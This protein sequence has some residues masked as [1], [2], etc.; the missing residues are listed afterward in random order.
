MATIQQWDLP[1][2]S[3]IKPHPGSRLS[4]KEFIAWCD[5]DIKAEWVNG[6]V[7]IMSP[8]TLLHVRI[9]R[10]LVSLLQEFGAIRKLG[11]ALGPEFTVRLD[12]QRRRIPDVLFV[13]SDRLNRLQAGYFEGAPNFIVEVVSEDSVERD[14][15]DKYFEYEAAGVD[16]YWI[17]D[18]QYQRIAPYSLGPD[19]VY[20]PIAEQ[21][22][23][24]FST[25]VP[26]FYLRAEWLWCEPLPNVSDLLPEL[27]AATRVS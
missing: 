13:A 4:E 22:G 17:V 24:F 9:S 25:A 27:L 18:P 16:E 20:C 1:G 23:R 19:G 7:I 14:W 3:A 6:E 11:E 21:D 26:G 10:L 12:A 15:R 5:E 8:A 2:C